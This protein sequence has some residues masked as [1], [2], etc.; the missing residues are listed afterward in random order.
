MRKHFIPAALVL[1]F[2]IG[3]QGDTKEKSTA[4]EI[5]KQDSAATSP[6][7]T[8]LENSTV[9]MALVNT[10]SAERRRIES[11]LDKTEKKTIS[12]ADAREKIKQKWQKMDVYLE[13]GKIVRIKTY[14]YPQISKRTEEFYFID[15]KLALV[16]IED[17]GLDSKEP[18]ADAEGK[19]YWFKND[20]L[21]HAAN[22]SDEAEI[23]NEIEVEGE[24]LVI[25]VAEYLRMIK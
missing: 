20:K 22:K 2:A 7:E 4:S 3:C 8:T 11:I 1:T 18:E 25:E 23:S 24:S 19:T 15:G 6:T 21:I 17:N 12:F 16:F 10:I 13:N 14:P 5:V 9:D